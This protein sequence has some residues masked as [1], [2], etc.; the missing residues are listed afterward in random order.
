MILT[1]GSET[2]DIAIYNFKIG[3]D[4]KFVP[5]SLAT[6]PPIDKPDCR[7]GMGKKRRGKR[8]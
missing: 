7:Y 8:P 1:L 6:W 4:K 2:T 5:G 3:A